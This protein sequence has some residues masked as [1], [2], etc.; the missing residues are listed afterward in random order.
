VVLTLRHWLGRQAREG[1]E[2]IAGFLETVG[3]GMDLDAINPVSFE[4]L[5]QLGP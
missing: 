3:D 2:A 1:E 4:V 5:G